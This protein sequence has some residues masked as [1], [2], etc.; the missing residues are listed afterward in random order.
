VSLG[1]EREDYWGGPLDPGDVDPD[2]IV[3]FRRWF[4]E[5]AG[6]GLRQPEAM[7]LATV[8]AEG[9]PHSRYML[10]KSV[11][12]RGFCFY[13]NYTSAKA[14]DLAERPHAALTFGW[15]VMHR[16]V[17][18]EGIAQRLPE[19]ES[20]AYFGSR[21]RDSQ[22]GAWA[23]PQSALLDSRRALDR[24]ALEAQQRFEGVDVPRPP[25]WGGFIVRPERVEFWQGRPSRLHDRVRYEREGGAWRIERLA[26]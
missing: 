26:P 2:P 16:S 12:D 13:T 24:S 25:H 21:P 1:L 22:I 20:D 14:R 18:V 4:S 6:A 5:A 9:R 8:D 7:T 11:D 23:S 10:L 3:Q 15:L 19:D 17:R